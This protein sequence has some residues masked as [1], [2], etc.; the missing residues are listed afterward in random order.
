[1]LRVEEANLRHALDLARTNRLWPAAVGCLQ[2]LNVL[3]ER[4]GRNGEWARIVAA[5][6]PDFADTETGAPLH[7]REKHWSTV[8]SYRV[9]VARQTQD[10]STATTLQHARI[11]WDRDQAAPA[12]QPCS[13]TGVCS[14]S[15]APRPSRWCSGGWPSLT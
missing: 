15:C 13:G 11:A 7:G 9:G 1:M 6:T 10:W 14:H 5:I 12:D 3:Y 4:T 8:T 2:G